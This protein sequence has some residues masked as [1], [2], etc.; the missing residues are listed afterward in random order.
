MCYI[1]GI[2]ADMK[3]TKVRRNISF[4]ILGIYL[5]IP[6]LITGFLAVTDNLYTSFFG[7]QTALS[8]TGGLVFVY[9][10]WFLITGIPFFIGVGVTI[11]VW[12]I[13]RYRHR[14]ISEDKKK[15]E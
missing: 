13:L 12:L 4:V 1:I 9:Y 5:V 3:N 6:F 7:Q 8:F 14:N 2:V 15:T 10:G 11:V